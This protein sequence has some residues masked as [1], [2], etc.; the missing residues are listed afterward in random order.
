MVPELEIV[1]LS[2]RNFDHLWLL[3]GR[4]YGNGERWGVRVTV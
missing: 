4:R 3:L 1:T 2:K